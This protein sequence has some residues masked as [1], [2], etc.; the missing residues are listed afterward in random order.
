MPC[1]PKIFS[2][3]RGSAPMVRR[4]AMAGRFSRTTIT[5]VATMLKAA[6]ATTSTRIRNIIV[7][8]SWIERKNPAWSRVQSLT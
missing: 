3:W 8:V 6:T 7:L 2:T 1:T 5:R 4:I